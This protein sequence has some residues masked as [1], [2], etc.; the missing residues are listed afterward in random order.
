METLLPRLDF[1]GVAVKHS[2][3]VVLLVP[4]HRKSKRQK[5]KVK[6]LID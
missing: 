5:E 2:E 3:E 1:S 6:K 4:S